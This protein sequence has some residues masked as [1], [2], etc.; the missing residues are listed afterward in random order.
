MNFKKLEELMDHFT[1]WRIPGCNCV[2]YK[3]REKVFEYSSGYSDIESGT[4][5]KGDEIMYMFSTTKPIVCATGLALWEKGKFDLDDPVEKFLPEWANMKVK[6]KHEDGTFDV[7]DATEKATMRHLFTMQAGLDYNTETE[8][9]KE[10]LAK[11]APECPT[12]EV[13]RAIAA[14]PLNFEPGEY[15]NYSLCHDVLG[16]A[17]E[18][19]EGKTLDKIVKEII[20]DPVGMT[21]TEF[22]MSDERRKRM[23]TMYGFNDT[24]VQIERHPTQDNWSIFGTEYYSG[25]AGLTSTVADMCKFAEMM[26]AGGVTMDG[27][28]ILKPE[29]I[30]LMKTNQLGEV[31]IKE[32]NWSHLVGYGYGMG[33]RTLMDPEAAKTKAPV[34]EFGWTGAAGAFELIDTDNKIAMFYAHHML[35]NQEY[36]TAPRLRDALYECIAAE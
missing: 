24:T 30:E 25:G 12:R 23:A 20:L 6:K 31:Q 21:D 29:T 11:F 19:I 22:G 9:M 33:V 32:F 17:L 2:V 34:G 10:C 3:D 28:R 36:Y 5:M 35:N 13:A 26:S 7:V 14:S 15:W 27:V 4:K 1:S 18:V 8:A 16:A